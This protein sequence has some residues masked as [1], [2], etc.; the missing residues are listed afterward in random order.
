MQK[1]NEVDAV[2]VV[3]RVVKFLDGEG[4]LDK[5]TGLNV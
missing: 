3:K 5:L 1:C 4:L 2:G